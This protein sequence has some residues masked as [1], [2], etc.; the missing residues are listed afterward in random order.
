MSKTTG[1]ASSALDEAE[2]ELRDATDALEAA[3][4]A[5]KD[6]DVR[7]AAGD[8][9]VDYDDVIRTPAILKL[10]EGRHSAAIA[11][12]REV[13]DVQ[14]L[15]EEPVARLSAGL[16][17]AVAEATPKLKAAKESA[18]A[19][20][21]AFV[22]A[23]AALEA[24]GAALEAA[25]AHL[26]ETVE[27][28]P[29]DPVWGQH[30]AGLLTEAGLVPCDIEIATPDIAETIRRGTLPLLRITDLGDLH[31]QHRL[32]LEY[33]TKLPSETPPN[34]DSIINVLHLDG[35]R[36]SAGDWDSTPGDDI[37][38]HTLRLSLTP[39]ATLAW[40]LD[41]DVA[42]ERH[43][44]WWKRVDYS[45]LLSVVYEQN[46][47]RALPLDG[48]E[49]LHCPEILEHVVTDGGL[50]TLSIG[51]A[52]RMYRTANAVLLTKRKD[53]DDAV[54]RAARGLI[55]ATDW[56][57][58]VVTDAEMISGAPGWAR[59]LV[60]EPRGAASDVVY[61]L[62]LTT[63]FRAKDGRALRLPSLLDGEP[64]Q[65]DLDETDEPSHEEGTPTR[66]VGVGSD[67]RSVLG[68]RELH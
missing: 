1:I 57:Y 29:V 30:V 63:A 24:A 28:S 65:R 47:P 58:G 53:I 39:R 35:W 31:E 23:E 25:E 34:P 5:V 14:P 36:V 44:R 8:T 33:F 18:E 43:D 55:G 6:L 17:E 9:T 54:A 3:R 67:V 27:S 40:A 20:R 21:A 41:V 22:A 56:E 10:A 48:I 13:E 60:V 46:S 7:I 66:K 49:A 38:T 26:S 64:L 45:S 51:A 12:L 68:D 4:Q 16:A 11:Y 52:I 2:Q 61:Y 59:H 19:Q 37:Q 15:P 50:H 42:G 62:K 32:T